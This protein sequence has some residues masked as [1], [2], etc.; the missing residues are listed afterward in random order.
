MK[1]NPKS[2]FA[3]LAIIA[4]ILIAGVTGAAIQTDKE[5]LKKSDFQK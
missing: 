3:I 5:V 1:S 2:G 4:T